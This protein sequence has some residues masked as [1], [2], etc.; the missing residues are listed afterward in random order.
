MVNVNVENRNLA[1]TSPASILAVAA[2]RRKMLPPTTPQSA[3]WFG[4]YPNANFAV[5]TGVDTVVLDLDIRPGKDGVA[6]LA[7]LESAA[8]QTLPATVTVLSGS[9]TGAKHLYFK[10]PQNV[11][12]LQKPERH[13]GH[14][15]PAITTGE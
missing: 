15:L 11:G 6:E 4:Q 3:Q 7:A 5:I 2:G 8:G 10:L 1:S 12:P 14:R 13:H 9:G